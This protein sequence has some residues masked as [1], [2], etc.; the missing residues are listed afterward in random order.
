MLNCFKKLPV[1]L[2]LAIVIS[3]GGLASADVLRI[4]GTGSAT[5]MLKYVGAAFTAASGIPIEVIIGLGSSGG[6]RAT[7][8]GVLNFSVSGRPLKPDEIATGL[9][10][11]ATTRTP[12]VLVTSRPNAQ[13]LKSAEIAEIFKSGRA[14]WADSTPIRI[15]LRP[16]SESDTA[17][18]GE[19]FPGLAAAIEAARLRTDVPLAAT[20]QDNAE[21]AERVEGSLTGT[22]FTQFKME[23]RR[24]HLIEIDGV[25]PTL[26]NFEN[27]TYR[28]GKILYFVCPTNENAMVARF[29]AFLQSPQGQSAL[30]ET[31]NLPGEA[32]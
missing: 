19:L 22:T 30:R 32:R 2:A 25:K 12:Y 17:L 31:G 29:I 16:R 21:L 14:T 7:A 20:D 18:M 10:Q 3:T 4:G 5:E 27:G 26:E 13:G 24:L 8:D 11:I 6:I 23:K 15:L 28:Y 9:T 1:S